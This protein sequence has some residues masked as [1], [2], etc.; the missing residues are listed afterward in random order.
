IMMTGCMDSGKKQMKDFAEGFAQHVKSNN[1]DSIQFYYP[2]AELAESFELVYNPDSLVIEKSDKE[3]VYEISYNSKV[4]MIAEITPDG[5]IKVK[6]SKGLFKYPDSKLKFAKKVGG[7]KAGMNDEELSKVM[8]NV[9]NLSTE[10]YNDYVK[11]R[12]NAIKNLGF[13]VTR[14]M[15]Y[16]MDYGE[17][18]YTLKNVTDQP[19]A[20]ED[21]EIT[22]KETEFGFDRDRTSNKIETGKADIPA[23]GTIKVK[24]SFTGHYY[25]DLVAITVHSPSK[26]DF[27]KKYTPTGEEY[28]A[29]VKVH[30]DTPVKRE[31][32]GYGPFLMTGKVGGKYAVH[33]TLNKGMK[34]GSYYY[35]KS[36]P[37]ATLDLS[38]KEYNENTGEVTIEE[39][40]K[41]GEVTGTFIGIL[42]PDSF[43]G[44]MTS[45]QGKT[46]DC[47]FKVSKTED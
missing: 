27:Y 3:G 2:G 42:T 10:L 23:N 15:E 11:E 28:A 30:G 7:L 13:T 43:V 17:G 9:D 46:Y 14:E 1:R 37:N 36:G 41:N 34:T 24:D 33:I 8:I 29:Y 39:K 31:A 21:Y 26:E 40:N 25:R 47:N 22:W 12:K 32:L 5:K 20:A 16:M 35:D 4:A 44:K 18:Y 6:E 19:I 45:F 38:V